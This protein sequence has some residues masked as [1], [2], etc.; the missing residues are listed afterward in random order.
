MSPRHAKALVAGILSGLLWV[1]PAGAHPHVWVTVKAEIV[2]TPD[3]T[4]TG[5]RHHWTFDDAFSAYATQGLGKDGKD[6]RREDL[7]ELAK[8]NVESLAEYKY[9]TGI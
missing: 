6:P 3:N 7:A 9:F 5:I 4:V 8:T 1:A 2:V